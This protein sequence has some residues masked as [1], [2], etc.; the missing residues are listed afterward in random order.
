M[1][2]LVFYLAALLFTYL[3]TYYL[4]AYSMEQNPSWEANRFSANQG[5]PCTSNPTSLKPI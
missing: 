4:L 3:L 1:V 2:V 5:I